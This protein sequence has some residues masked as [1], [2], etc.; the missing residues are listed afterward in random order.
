MNGVMALFHKQDKVADC[1]FDKRGYLQSVDKIYNEK[2]LPIALNENPTLDLQRWILG[3]GLSTNR[4]DL[5][6]YR[7]FYG[8]SSFVSKN[9]ISLF[10]TYWFSDGIETD[11]EKVNAFD[12]WDC[13]KDSYFQM[14]FQ[15]Q[16]LFEI[17]TNS[18]NLEISGP[19]PRLWY[20]NTNGSLMLLYR[21]AQ[22]QM[23]KCNSSD[24]YAKKKYDI[25]FGNICATLPAFTS[26]EVECLNFEDL[27]NTC[28][29]RKNSK[30]ENLQATCEALGLSDWK[31]FFLKVA[32][33]EEKSG[34]A[35]ELADI[36][37]LRDTKTLETIGFAPL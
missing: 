14:I 21:D 10:D 16:E 2:L 29:N 31:T 7:E 17:D 8:G 32:E 19:A 4:R 15:A 26:K 18:P 6:R 1:R 27:Y 11:W 12:N 24:L 22:N 23:Q 34:V 28:K 20:R 33:E 9:G 3:R 37:V 30:F 25:L 35:F 36:G 13:K 5:T